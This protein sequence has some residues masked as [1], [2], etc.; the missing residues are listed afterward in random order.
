[1]VKVMPQYKRSLGAEHREG[2]PRS[3]ITAVVF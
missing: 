2:D 3:S 1:M